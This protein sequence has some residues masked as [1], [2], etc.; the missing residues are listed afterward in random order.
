[1]ELLV[2]VIWVGS[3]LFLLWAAD[4]WKAI[5]F[6]FYLLHSRPRFDI[7][8]IIGVFI[9]DCGFMFSYDTNY[10]HL[11]LVFTGVNGKHWFLFGEQ[12]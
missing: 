4:F 3:V 8:V 2:G 6:K 9:S 11:R 12:K 10:K 5:E 7:F 1:M